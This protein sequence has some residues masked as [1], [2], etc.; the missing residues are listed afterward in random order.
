MYYYLGRFD[1]A[2]EAL[3]RALELTPN[4]HLRWSN[5]GDIL[6]IDGKFEAAHDAFA[7]A[8]ALANAALLVNSNDPSVMMDLA[9]IHAM[10][11]DEIQ[12][13]AFIDKAAAALPDD[14]YADFI[15]ALVHNRSGN[16]DKALDAL[17]AA[18]AKGYAR[19]IIAAEPHLI[20]LRGHPRFEKITGA[21]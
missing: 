17:E 6:F 5:L 15:E 7:K 10:L 1:D 19:T 12:A 2:A 18:A 11:D 13:L 16:T 9:W 21:D 3:Q 14:P 20:S 8:E 4:A